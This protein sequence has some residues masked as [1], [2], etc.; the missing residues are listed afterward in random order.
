MEIGPIFRAL[1]RNKA[2]FLL[3]SLEM[4]LTL[5]IALNCIN[6][7]QDMRRQ[8]NRAT[9]LDEDNIIVAQSLPFAP[10]FKEEG[11]LE[12]SRKVDL[13]LLRG[14]PG[15]RLTLCTAAQKGRP[16]CRG[17]AI[18]AAGQDCLDCSWH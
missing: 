5:A 8:M 3:V 13:E 7:I 10:D 17:R 18:G 1:T 12:N 2:R 11:Y 9:G 6:L 4:A 15:V 16:A 14:L